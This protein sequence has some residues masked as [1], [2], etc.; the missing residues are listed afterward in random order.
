MKKLLYRFST[1]FLSKYYPKPSPHYFIEEKRV[2]VDVLVFEEFI[3]EPFFSYPKK[4]IDDSALKSRAARKL[5]ENLL[6]RGYIRFETFC[7]EPG[8]AL[9]PI[10]FRAEMDVLNIEK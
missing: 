3:P 8:S 10:T 9:S 7:V 2:K 6:A 5:S 4:L 1:W